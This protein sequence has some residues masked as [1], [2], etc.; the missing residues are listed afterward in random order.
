MGG[1]TSSTLIMCTDYLPAR[2]MMPWSRI[3]FCGMEMTSSDPMAYY[4]LVG[5]QLIFPL[6]HRKRLSEGA[7]AGGSKLAASQNKLPKTQAGARSLQKRSSDDLTA[8]MDC[9]G[10]MSEIALY[11]TWPPCGPTPV[12]FSL[13][14]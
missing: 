2:A 7:R 8:Y 14:T 1:M 9:F 3:P 5:L 11:R 13:R 6:T 10:S 12:L 4:A